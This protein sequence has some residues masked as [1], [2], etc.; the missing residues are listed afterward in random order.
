M[1]TSNQSK[2]NSKSA[3]D[4]TILLIVD[5]DRNKDQSFAAFDGREMDER[6]EDYRI[7]K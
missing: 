5:L 1:A 2:L 3:N 7:R 4:E 6:C